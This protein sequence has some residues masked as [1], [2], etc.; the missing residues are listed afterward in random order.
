MARLKFEPFPSDPISLYELVR[1]FG[2]DKPLKRLLFLA[3][4][5]GCQT[6]VYQTQIRHS[7]FKSEWDDFYCN[8]KPCPRSTVDKLN[9]FSKPVSSASD[10]GNMTSDDFLGYVILRPIPKQRVCEAVLRT[11]PE[12]NGCYVLAKGKHISYVGKHKFEV[13]GTPFVQQDSNCGV[14][15]HASLV[16]ISQ[17]IPHIF[18][19]N[20]FQPWTVGQIKKIV[21]QISSPSAGPG[22]NLAQV[23]KV[24]EEMGYSGDTFYEFPKD[25]PPRFQPEQIIYMYVESKIPV[26]IGLPLEVLGTGHSIVVCGHLLDKQSWWPEALPSYYTR[27]PSGESWLS[28]VSWANEW[29]ITDDNFGPYLSMPKHLCDVSWIAVPLPKQI[30]VKGEMATLNTFWTLHTPMF[31]YLTDLA[32]KKRCSP[33]ID[34]FLRHLLE[35]KIVFRQFLTTAEEF[36]ESI[37]NDDLIDRDLAEDYLSMNLPEYIWVVELS[38]PELFGDALRLGEIIINACYPTR[39]IDTGHEALL[40]IHGPGTWQKYNMDSSIPSVYLIPDDK[41]ARMLCR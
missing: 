8:M 39:F 18:P 32:S 5:L 1:K 19:N 26:F 17:I 20:S 6:I 12:S 2:D 31:N 29:I 30:L 3:R 23:S 36:K 27:I 22:L 14:C 35:G 24:F 33:W 16:M 15:A 9:F 28:S 21:S 7:G 38:I 4:D 10:L 40:A 11:P 37:R 41:P 34:P 25:N 13:V